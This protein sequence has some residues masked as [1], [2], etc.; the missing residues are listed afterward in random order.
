MN[1]L[2]ILGRRN[3]LPLLMDVVRDPG[4]TIKEYTRGDSNR[5]TALQ[6][7]RAYGLVRYADNLGDTRTKTV[8]PTANGVRL[9]VLMD[10]A[11]AILEAPQ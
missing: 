4:L 2:T 5:H 3:A 8:H 11:L 1:D 10:D 6:A 7:L 9:A